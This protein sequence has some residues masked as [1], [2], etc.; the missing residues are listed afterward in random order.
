MKYYKFLRAVY[1]IDPTARISFKESEY[2]QFD[3]FI[4]TDG[5]YIKCTLSRDYR[6]FNDKPIYSV[7]MFT[8]VKIIAPNL[9]SDQFRTLTGRSYHIMKKDRLDILKAQAKKDISQ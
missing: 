3:A 9:V 8:F 2:E 6:Q 1:A 5:C 7:W 4:K